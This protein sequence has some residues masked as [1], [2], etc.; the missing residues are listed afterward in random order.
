G[1]VPI[2]KPGKL[3]YQTLSETYAL[4]YGTDEIQIHTDA[5]QKGQPV[6]LVD[7]L[8][9]TGGTMAAA[10]ALIGRLGGDIRGASFLIE[11][12]F[13]EGRK[14]FSDQEVHSLITY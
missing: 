9:A 13:L 3:P 8:L 6:A 2:R 11:L 4:E 1:F 5:I 14:R 7:D 12:A 10:C